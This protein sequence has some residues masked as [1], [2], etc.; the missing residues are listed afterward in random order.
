MAVTQETIILN[1]FG[2]AE[3]RRT[4]GASGK[5]KSRFTVSIKADAI[6]HLFD[7]QE[8]GRGPAEA[9][10]QVIRDQI[11]A[12]GET[13]SLGTQF[14]RKAAAKAFAAGKEWAV[15]RYSG[16][17]TGAT[18]PKGGDKLFN[19]SG[20]LA[21]GIY[22]QAVKDESWT[23]N[24]PANRFDPSTF[25]GGVAALTA[26]VERLQ[27]LVPALRGE[28]LAGNET[29]RRA[30]EN[31]AADIFVRVDNVSK[32]KGLAVARGLLTTMRQLAAGLDLV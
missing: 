28:G 14:A 24:V 15:A 22:V 3:R 32:Q 29:L 25:N 19:D 26:M 2:F 12:I 31:A 9:I 5:P 6:P 10:A 11:K 7:A 18:P 1:E 27:Q 20:R 30:M 13:A 21:D 17:R 23:I 4:T 16:G 8:L